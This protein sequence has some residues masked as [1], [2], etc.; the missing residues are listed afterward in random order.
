MDYFISF[1]LG[2]I[3]GW[4]AFRILLYIKVQNMLKSIAEETPQPTEPKKINI[5]FVRMKERIYAYN[6]DNNHFLASGDT[7]QE[8]IDVLGKRFP[9]TN[10]MASPTNLKEVGFNE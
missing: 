2:A 8:I 3:G 10:F 9:G 4:I 1:I 6:R 5:D 7:K